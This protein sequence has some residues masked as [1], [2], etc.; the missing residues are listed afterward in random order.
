MSLVVRI[1]GIT[2][3]VTDNEQGKSLSLICASL[4]WL[5]NHKSNQFEAS[6]QESAESYKDEPSWLVEQLLRRKREELVSRWEERE[7][8]LETLRVKEKAQEDRARKRRRVEDSFIS[9]GRSRAVEDEDAEWLLDDPDDRDATPQDSL[10][11]LS[12]E[13]RE[14]LASIG[15]GGARKPEEEDDLVEEPIKVRIFAI[16]NKCLVVTEIDLLH[17]KNTFPAFAIYHRTTPPF[18]SSFTANVACEKRRGENRSSQTTATIVSS[19][20]MHQSLSLS[21]RLRTSYQRPLL[22]ASAA[23]VGSKM[24][25]RPQRR[26]CFTNSSVSRLGFS[27]I[28]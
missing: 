9:S 6:I 22:G 11:G 26:S 7:K 1:F 2:K 12:K 8:R 21:V 25:L 4:T 24:S 27:Y 17:V 13:T 28:A 15:L 19:K 14:V 3:Q 16:S 5:R 18:I 10:S 20:V 23:Q